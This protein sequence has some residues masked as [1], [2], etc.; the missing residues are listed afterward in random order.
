[1]KK[2]GSKGVKAIKE[3]KKARKTEFALTKQISELHTTID[4]LDTDFAT[5]R[6]YAQIL[7]AEQTTEIEELETELENVKKT[8]EDETAEKQ[9]LQTNVDS[10]KKKL[11]TSEK[12][13][14]EERKKRLPE[15]YSGLKK[16]YE[17]I[18]AILDDTKDE[19]ALE[20]KNYEISRV[21]FGKMK[22]RAKK[23]YDKN[24]DLLSEKKAQE[25]TTTTT[26]KTTRT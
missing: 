1:M 7:E 17:R 13:L 16:E 24:H 8:L 26:T 25:T 21:E 14:K 2:Q 19:L 4:T 6:N 10:M 12:D 18:K 20:K 15:A 11:A 22:R 3:L 9:E 23:L 5:L